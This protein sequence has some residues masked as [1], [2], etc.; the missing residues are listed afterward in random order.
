MSERERLVGLVRRIMKGDYA[1]DD[2][3]ERLVAEFE[4]GVPRPGASD[5][6]FHWQDEFDHEPTA[7]EVVGRALASRPIEL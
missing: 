5:L 1:T 6:L 2:D 3:V 4:A 7:T